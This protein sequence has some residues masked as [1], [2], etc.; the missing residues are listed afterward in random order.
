[1]N[2]TYDWIRSGTFRFMAPLD[3]CRACVA[4]PA[5]NAVIIRLRVKVS[6]RELRVTNGYSYSNSNSRW[7][8]AIYE[9]M[10]VI[11]PR[12]NMLAQPQ[13][14]TTVPTGRTFSLI[15]TKLIGAARPRSTVRPRITTLSSPSLPL[16]VSIPSPVLS[17]KA[18]FLKVFL[19]T[20]LGLASILAHRR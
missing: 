20:P 6:Y 2:C 7:L 14:S 9:T 13:R 5:C 8:Y 3:Y 19:E 16:R 12:Q 1:M 17:L 15:D 10:R 11:L 18:I 4:D